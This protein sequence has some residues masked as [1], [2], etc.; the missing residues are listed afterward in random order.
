V[1]AWV[2]R[3]VVLIAQVV[4]VG[5]VLILW[6][7]GSTHHVIDPNFFSSPGAV[8]DEL[9][10][11]FSTG[12]I[13]GNLSA[14]LF[15]FAAG[16]AIGTVVGVA[17]GAAIGLSG[18]IREFMAPFLAFFNA[19]PRLVLLPL[20]VVWFGFGYTPRVVLVFSVVVVIV[21]INVGR[22]LQEVRTDLI[23]DA[24]IKGATR[25]QLFRH[26]YSPSMGLWVLSTARVTV[27]YAIDTAVA[28]EFI[29]AST[30]LGYLI[31]YGQ[32]QVRADEIFAA[33]VLTVVIAFIV[34]RCLVLVER[35]SLKWMPAN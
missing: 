24:K 12:T 31:Y 10:I 18:R 4:L 17:L 32:A 7:V 19:M 6:Q 15:E 2:A 16:Y 29:G 22:G 35:R 9:Y 34:D 8:W 27:G 14:T 21:T 30:G 23:D 28:A 25:L 13:W 11:W 1:N 20:F 26:V 33:L 5:L 3:A